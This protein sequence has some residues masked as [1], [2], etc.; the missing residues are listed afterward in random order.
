MIEPRLDLDSLHA[1][2]V[3]AEECNFTRAASRLHLSQPSLHVKVK[4]LGET[5]GVALYERRGR[6]LLLTPHGE[7][8]LAFAREMTA[9]ERAFHDELLGDAADVTPVVLAAGEGALLYLL[10]DALK[11]H[12]ARKTAAPLRILTRDARGTLDAVRR[13]EAQ[14]GVGPVLDDPGDL[15]HEPLIRVGMQL[16]VRNDHSLANR[17]KLRLG[18]LDGLPLVIPPRGRAHRETVERAMAAND[19]RLDVA[20]EAGGWQLMLHF[21]KQGLGA[22]IVNDFCRP[23]AGTVALPLP[24]LPGLDYELTWNPQVH[25]PGARRLADTIRRSVQ[26]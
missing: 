20:V 16:V 6:R 11:T 18:Q 14:L 5:L 8:L 1:F 10:A 25:G 13:G 2:L 24:E 21:A 9:R 19:A 15:A 23:P 4:K 3:F 12:R 17:K 7:R 26:S 22:A